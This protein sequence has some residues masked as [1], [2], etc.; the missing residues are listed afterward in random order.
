MSSEITLHSEFQ[1]DSRSENPFSV[2]TDFFIST[3]WIKLGNQVQPSQ[4]KVDVLDPKNVGIHD[5]TD[6]EYLHRKFIATLRVPPAHL[7]FEKD[8]N[9]KATLTLQD[10]QFVRFLRS[11]QQQVGQG[12]E[13]I[14]KI[15]LCF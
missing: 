4:A 9:A 8:V 12:L 1:V 14:F 6:V 11:I 10:T 13:Q 7:G 2:M 5:I 15:S 3:G